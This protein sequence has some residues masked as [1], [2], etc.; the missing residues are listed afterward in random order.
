MDVEVYVP[1]IGVKSVEVIEILVK[2][3]DEV[4]KEDGLISV[5]SNKSVL[6]IPSPFSG[7]I[8]KISVNVGDKLSVNNLIMILEN[9]D[10]NQYLTT[11]TINDSNLYD[12]EQ[13]NTPHLLDQKNI[14]NNVINDIYASPKVR[15]IARLLN[16]NLLNL[17]GSG[18][19]GRITCKDIEKYNMKQMSNTLCEHNTG[20]TDSNHKNIDHI[21]D[22]QSYQSLTKIQRISGNRLLNNWKNIP[23][24][25]QFNEADITDLEDFRKLYNSRYLHDKSYKKISI[26]S[27]LVKSVIRALLE[28][29]RFNSVLHSSNNSII[30]KKNI[31]I[32]IAVD[33]KDGLLVPV[34]K[35]LKNKNISEISYK[36]FDI[37]QKAK[38]NKLD[39]HD[40]KDGS[41]TISSLGGIGGTGFTPIINAPEACILG[42]SKAT[43]KPIWNQKKF[44]PRLILPFSLSY[45]HRIIDGADGVRFTNFLVQL[46]SDI[47]TLLM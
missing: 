28:Y 1:D 33:T 9:T 34:L 14:I 39:I 4:K 19:K 41:F 32:G 17:T 23:H 45:D 27:F 35:N 15:R 31:N 24:V 26:L 43:I 12:R 8:K 3:G 18:S 2:I 38:N 7:I 47:R 40:M 22:N 30:L 20:Y 10:S 37:V 25:T 11:N 44:Y 16:I 46:L 5:E 6:E 36:I 29:P 13:L 42:I 21:D